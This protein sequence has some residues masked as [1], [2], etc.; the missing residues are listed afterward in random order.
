MQVE[1]CHLLERTD[2]HLFAWCSAEVKDAVPEVFP[3]IEAQRCE[4]LSATRVGSTPGCHPNI[5]AVHHRWRRLGKY[6][7]SAGAAALQPDLLRSDPHSAP[8]A[9]AN[10]D[11][12]VTGA[13]QNQAPR[14]SI[15]EDLARRVANVDLTVAELLE[16]HLLA[17]ERPG[18]S[19]E[20][21]A[22]AAR[23]KKGVEAW[24]SVL[25]A[26]KCKPVL[27]AVAP[28]EA[29]SFGLAIAQIS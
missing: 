12:A 28:H 14:T 7:K 8:L 25:E 11:R 10:A 16:V 17:A 2:L 26:R 18:F 23:Y 29:L 15:H 5:F 27:L 22:G 13:D 6:V 3:G 4:V 9:I 1:L 21:L 24:V 20:D 19:N